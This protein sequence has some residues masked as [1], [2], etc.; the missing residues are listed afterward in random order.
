V[1]ADRAASL[2]DWLAPTRAALLIVDMQVDFGAPDGALGRAGVDLSAVPAALAG[3]ERLADAARQAGVTVIFVGL[4]T[5]PETDSAAWFERARR[6][7]GD[8]QAALCRDG[9]PGAA[10]I[11]PTPS[12]DELVIAKTRYSAFFGTRLD[13]ILRSR[14]LDTLVVCGLTTECCI[15]CSVRDAFHL[16]YQLFV[17]ADACAAYEADLHAGAL[18]SLALNCAILVQVDDAIEAWSAPTGW[19]G[20]SP[21]PPVS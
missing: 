1:T 16:D 2:A 5:H 20:H 4:R 19:S 15:D 17:A 6:L 12:A 8:T 21:G 9:E 13:E 10:F 14:G 18:K 7:G 11:G 3:A